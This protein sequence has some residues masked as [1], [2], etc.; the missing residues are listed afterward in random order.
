MSLQPLQGGWSGET[1]LAEAAGERSVVRIFA[2]PGHPPQAAEIQAA[3]LTLVRGL[4]PVP[5]VLELRHAEP[6]NGQPALLVTELLP[7]VR[8]DL[9]LP[10]LD[11]VG[12]ATVGRQLGAVAATLAGMP[13]LVTGTFV[14]AQ[15]TVAPF[16]LDVAGW[17][18]DHEPRLGLDDEELA[19]LHEVSD[20]A[21]DLLDGVDRVCLVHSDLNPK[22]LLLD[23]ETLEVTGVLDWEFAHAGHP[24]TDLGNL[25]R[26]DRAQ[27]YVAGVLEGFVALRGGTAT[28]SL[29]LAR[30]ADLVALVELASRAADNPVAA[31]AADLLRSIARHRDL[32]AVPVGT[33]G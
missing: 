27:A 16:D 17:V 12:R 18:A 26:F 31:R 14:D 24:F 10:T 13:Q 30:A 3:L 19:G 21:Q 15:L 9:V 32:H 11:D 29:D 28:E 25:L 23:P 22:N 8:G 33:A 4:L 5:R 1:F 6:A 7:G 2:K 20:A